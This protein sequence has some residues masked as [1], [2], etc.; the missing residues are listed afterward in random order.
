MGNA[1]IFGA[2][3]G[4]GVCTGAAGLC[5]RSGQESALACSVSLGTQ[6]ATKN[7][8][9]GMAVCECVFAACQRLFCEKNES[10]PTRQSN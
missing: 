9:G 1:W 7:W 8:A 5:L 2:P 4:A 3:S 6:A 10:P